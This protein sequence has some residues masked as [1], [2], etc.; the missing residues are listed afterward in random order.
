MPL[1]KLAKGPDFLEKF[2]KKFGTGVQL[3]APYVYDAVMVMV[4]SMKRADSVEPTKYL[5]QV[6]KTKLEGVT[7]TI[8][9]D[10]KG[11]L[12][13]SAISFYRYKEGKLD[14][15]ETIGGAPAPVAAPPATEPVPATPP[16]APATTP[17]AP[18]AK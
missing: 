2:T 7:S 9:F 3:Y 15:V 14:Y 6:G 16:A 10:D 17:A 1:D 5:V 18:A 13:N 12:K 4:D 8:E 11:D